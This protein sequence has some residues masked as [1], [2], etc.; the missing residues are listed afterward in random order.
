MSD[1]QDVLNQLTTLKINFDDK[2]QVLLLL[3]SLPN[4]WKTLVVIVSNS[5]PNGKLTL[6]MVKDNMFN[7]KTRRKDMES[8]S[9]QA[10]VVENKGKT[11]NRY[12]D[13]R[14]RTKSKKRSKSKEVV[15]YYYCKKTGHIKRNC[16][17]LK[18]KND[19]KG[20]SVSNNSNATVV[21][22]NEGIK[23]LVCTP[24]N[25]NH[26]GDPLSEWIVDTGAAY[27]C[28]PK[29]ELFTTYK[30]CDFGVAKMGNNIVSQIIGI[31]DIIVKTS[32]GCTLT[33]RDARHIPDMRINLLS[34][35]ILNKEGYESQQKNTQWKL[36]KGDAT[37]AIL[38]LLINFRAI[39]SN[40]QP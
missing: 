2:V 37:V 40:K 20:K 4:N 18:E 19:E 3:S 26:V 22:S 39:T 36:L 30:E 23:S 13:S 15:K 32:T 16:Q 1:F 11:K 17:L 10:L 35:N 14:G 29:R 24:R 8:G 12:Q 28:V 6:G 7:K 31:G 9:S 34:I 25:C 33:L 21:G 27:H 5:A 38:N